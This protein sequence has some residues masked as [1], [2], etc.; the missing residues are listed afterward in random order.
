VV[1]VLT[2]VFSYIFFFIKYNLYDEFGVIFSYFMLFFN[3]IKFYVMR[4]V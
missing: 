1:Y 2:Q 3:L 4:D